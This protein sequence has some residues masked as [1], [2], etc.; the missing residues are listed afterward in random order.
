ML[1]EAPRQARASL[2]HDRHPPPKIKVPLLTLLFTR[3]MHPD[4]SGPYSLIPLQAEMV[5]VTPLLKNPFT[6]VLSRLVM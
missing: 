2:P 5:L 6:G 4:H 3:P 1:V